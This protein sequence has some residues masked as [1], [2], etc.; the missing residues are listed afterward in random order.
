MRTFKE[1][2]EEEYQKPH[3]VLNTSQLKAIG[4][5]RDYKVYVHSYDHPIYIRSD[6]H[7]KPGSGVR[8]YVLAN[9]A[10][11]HK[12]HV[13]ITTRGAILSHSIYAKETKDGETTWR[14]IKSSSG[15]KP[16]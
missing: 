5:H 2:L 8:N 9:G 3:Q 7:D 16:L 13:G 10:Q 4:N 14:H 6:E 15:G 12:M 11:K 1:F